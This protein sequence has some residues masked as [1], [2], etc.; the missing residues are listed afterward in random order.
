MRE[1]RSCGSVRE[2]GGDESLYSEVILL[3]NVHE[4]NDL[5]YCAV[6]SFLVWHAILVTGLCEAQMTT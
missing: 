1:M 4:V 3:S 5:T 6:N 2:R